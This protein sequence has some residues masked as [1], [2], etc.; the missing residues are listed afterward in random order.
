MEPQNFMQELIEVQ[1]LLKNE[2]YETAII[3]L[4]KLREIEK[5]GDFD[6]SLTHKLYQLISNAH[7]LYNQE[8]ILDLINQVSKT[9]EQITIKN[10]ALSLNEERNLELSED[11]IRREL[12]ILILRGLTSCKIKD[13]TLIF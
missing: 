4:E 10:I 7:S 2:K 5:K 8:Q 11:M 12:E 6:Y 13:E 9:Q 3:R 1:E